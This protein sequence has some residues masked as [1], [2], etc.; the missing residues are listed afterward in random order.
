ML[1]MFSM[2]VIKEVNR[3]EEVQEYSP[4]DDEKV[5]ERLHSLGYL[6]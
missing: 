1:L 5:K 2:E 4:K 6:D 3:E